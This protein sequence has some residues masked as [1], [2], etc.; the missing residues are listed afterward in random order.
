M[1]P[2]DKDPALEG[3]VEPPEE[4]VDTIVRGERGRFAPGH[5]PNPNG[6][7]KGIVSFPVILRNLLDNK[8]IDDVDL[9]E[10]TE[11]EKL[12]VMLI[13]KAKGQDLKALEMLVDRMEGKSVAIQ[14]ID[15]TATKSP[16]QLFREKKYSKE[17]EE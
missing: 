10:L 8:E 6:R 7:P 14:K 16:F 2:E 5:C 3:N 15:V 13:N 12:M 1:T 4:H 17:E 11:K 9:S